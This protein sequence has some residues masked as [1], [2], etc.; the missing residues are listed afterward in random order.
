MTL[1]KAKTKS[2][3]SARKVGNPRKKRSAIK[4]AAKARLPAENLA[5]GV[6]PSR[7]GSRS[8]SR[9]VS[10][11]PAPSEEPAA[12]PPKQEAVLKLLHQP[13]GT[14]IAAMM[15]A[16]DWQQHSVRGFLAGVVKKKLKLTLVSEKLD[17]TRTYRIGKPDSER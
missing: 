11:K 9:H 16:T 7:S 2:T 15:E 13:K 12:K 17:G 4:P 10:R 5:A 3:R 6:A 14:T 8:V 1:A